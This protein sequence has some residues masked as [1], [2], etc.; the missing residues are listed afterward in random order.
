MKQILTAI[1][2]LIMGTQLVFASKLNSNIVKIDGNYIHY[3]YQNNNKPKNLVL[4]TGSGTT[5]NFWPKDFIQKLSK[6]YNIYLLDYRCFNTGK[7]CDNVEYSINSMANDTNAFVKKYIP[8]NIYLLGW[9]LGGGVALQAVFNDPTAY[10]HLFLLAPVIPFDTQLPRPDPS[11]VKTSNAIYNMIFNQ[12]LY[13][14]SS[15]DLGKEKSRFINP[16]ISKLLLSKNQAKNEQEAVLL[17]FKSTKAKNSFS[18]IKMSTTVF[19]PDHDKMLDETKANEIFINTHNKN[20]NLKHM[21]K[22][23]HA[24]AWDKTSSVAKTINAI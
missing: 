12:I 5:T 6:N 23:G 16:K 1:T 20:Y 11:K 15:K 2:I 14:Y 10:Q 17:W 24:V 22:S 21:K 4:L 13:N 8:K 7:S 3:Y 19:I 9:S 18:N